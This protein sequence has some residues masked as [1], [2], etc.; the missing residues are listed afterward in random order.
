MGSKKSQKLKLDQYSI[1]QDF[2]LDLDAKPRGHEPEARPLTA[3]IVGGNGGFSN[4]KKLPRLLWDEF[5]IAVVDHVNMSR[6]APIAH[7]KPDLV[8]V[9]CDQTSHELARWGRLAGRLFI[10]VP[11]SWGRISQAIGKVGL[12]PYPGSN[13]VPRDALPADVVE[14]TGTRAKPILE[15]EPN[16]ILD[17][18]EEL[19][20]ERTE[21]KERQVVEA[22]KMLKELLIDASYIQSLDLAYRRETGTMELQI[23]RA[24]IEVT[25]TEI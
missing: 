3:F 25:T 20:P 23:S 16:P 14:L 21:S 17:V 1:R 10:S 7:A 11:S 4:I 9:L 13:F 18:K 5:A 15:V 19:M 8:I 2:I 22:V 24:I 6:R 12:S